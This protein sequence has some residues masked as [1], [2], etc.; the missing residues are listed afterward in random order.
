MQGTKRSATHASGP[1][2]KSICQLGHAVFI[3][4]FVKEPQVHIDL[5]GSRLPKCYI[6]SGFLLKKASANVSASEICSK[7]NSNFPCYDSF[8]YNQKNFSRTMTIL[9]E[10]LNNY[11]NTS[12]LLIENFDQNIHL[13]ADG[14]PTGGLALHKTSDLKFKKEDECRICRPPS[15]IE[16]TGA[17]YNHLEMITEQ[18]ESYYR[19]QLNDNH[20]VNEIYQSLCHINLVAA[21]KFNFSSKNKAALPVSGFV[22]IDELKIGHEKLVQKYK[23]AKESFKTNV[24]I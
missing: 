17:D 21:H 1:S 2:K 3:K 23:A 8:K 4:E 22:E 19:S 6:A 9:K 7:F 10:F 20:T 18:V 11:K 16:R 15:T 14:D 13:T 12:K 24:T 5:T